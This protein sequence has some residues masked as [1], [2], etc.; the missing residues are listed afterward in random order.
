MQEATSSSLVKRIYF[1]PYKNVMIETVCCENNIDEFFI[2]NE[3][4]NMIFSLKNE[5]LDV[6]I[7]LCSTLSVLV[8][9]ATKGL[10]SL[11]FPNKDFL[12]RFNAFVDFK[13]FDSALGNIAT[14]C[15]I[16]KNITKMVLISCDKILTI[17]MT[18]SEMLFVFIDSNEISEEVFL[19]IYELFVNNFMCNPF[20]K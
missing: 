14:N 2:V 6:K 20:L 4:G 12:I 17:Y 9:H 11:E 13:Q 16:N 18:V 15:L 10:A 8:D 7:T 3:T 19:K 1:Y 5:P